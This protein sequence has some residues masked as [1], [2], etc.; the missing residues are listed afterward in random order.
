[1]SGFSVKGVTRIDFFAGPLEF[2][3]QPLSFKELAANNRCTVVSR[4]S[5]NGGSTHDHAR[6]LNEEMGERRA[7]G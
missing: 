2:Q 7:T 4:R 6:E 3:L 5:S 1:M